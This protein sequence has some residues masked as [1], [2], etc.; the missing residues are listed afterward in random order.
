MPTMIT[1]SDMRFLLDQDFYDRSV[2]HY[3]SIY[4]N[5][6]IEFT[7]GVD[8]T[9]ALSRVPNGT[10]QLSISSRIP[11]NG[12]DKIPHTIIKLIIANAVY[13]AQE[14]DEIARGFSTI[15]QFIN[16]FI[17]TCNS[18][19][20][21]T[22]GQ[23]K[24]ILKSIPSSIKSL[25]LI[26]AEFG[27]RSAADVKQIF[28]FLSRDLLS[29]QLGANGLG[30]LSGVELA[31]AFSELPQRLHVLCLNA[32][33]LGRLSTDELIQSF[34]ALPQQLV[35]LDLSGN[36]LH[37][38]SVE[39][40]SRIF[41][42]LPRSV[43]RLKIELFQHSDPTILNNIIIALPPHIKAVQFGWVSSMSPDMFT[44]A[45][46]KNPHIR[47]ILIRDQV[48]LNNRQEVQQLPVVAEST[49]SV[50]VSPLSSADERM[51]EVS[52]ESHVSD[53]SEDDS[54]W[55]QLSNFSDDDTSVVVQVPHDSNETDD[56]LANQKLIQIRR[57]CGH[58]LTYA[59]E[60]M[61]KTTPNGI[62][63]DLPSPQR[64]QSL[65]EKYSI[66]KGLYDIANVKSA[67][68][69]AD[70]KA[71]CVQLEQSEAQLK[72][73][74]D[75]VLIRF[76]A[77]ILAALT[78]ICSSKPTLSEHGFWKK[79]RGEELHDS[80]KQTLHCLYQQQ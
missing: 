14:V 7:E 48:I 54:M 49:N 28:S 43:T 29:L 80:L 39:D 27:R 33:A 3:E 68:P 19:N 22:I 1:E 69:S 71:F 55:D 40:L 6:S 51:L 63:P 47:E 17:F 57:L 74:R 78:S 77:A 79:A 26:G 36:D 10:R 9:R 60:K 70:L 67:T 66:V 73:H 56:Q 53:C 20:K 34:A 12:F 42:A 2:S 58:Y 76:F 18:L 72:V 52:T 50:V 11:K 59:L 37:R 38:R 4:R 23:L 25:R 31:D 21:S 45:L 13:T 75:H 65:E 62:F 46:S 24:T 64:T 8:F 16:E 44:H 61:H 5:Y 30:N 35:E 41:A 15:P 32:N